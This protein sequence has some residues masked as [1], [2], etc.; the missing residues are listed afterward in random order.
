LSEIVYQLVNMSVYIVQKIVELW[1]RCHRIKS[2]AMFMPIFSYNLSASGKLNHPDPLPGLCPWTPCGI[3]SLTLR[4]A[5]FR[6]R[7]CPCLHGR[8]IQDLCN[9]AIM[10]RLSMSQ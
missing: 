9:Y 7:V 6:Y 1:K 10:C 4:T 5:T 2:K 3:S 8:H